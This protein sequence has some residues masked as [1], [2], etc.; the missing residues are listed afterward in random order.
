MKKIIK[1]L[2]DLIF[3]PIK[4]IAVLFA[5]FLLMKDFLIFS[6]ANK[7][8]SNLFGEKLIFKVLLISCIIVG[9]ILGWIKIQEVGF[10]DL[11]EIKKPEK[12]AEDETVN[13]KT[14]RNEEYGFEFKYPEKTDLSERSIELVVKEN[15]NPVEA[16]FVAYI[17]KPFII[18]F[19]VLEKPQSFSNLEEYVRTETENINQT[20][21]SAVPIR[22]EFDEFTIGGLKGFAIKTTAADVLGNTSIEIYF[23]KL[24][25]LFVIG[26]SY[27]QTLLEEQDPL[28]SSK[29]DTIQK[30]ISTFRL[31]NI[32]E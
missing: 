10:P 14:Y 29:Y 17:E 18:G 13:W 23:E 3:L 24:D 6:E 11:A 15:P 25:Y 8:L 21:G 12:V 5:S 31:E 32:I 20:E 22:A 16:V 4:I 28:E 7:K 30:I 19:Q 1:K 27:S 9:A 26:Y 2:L